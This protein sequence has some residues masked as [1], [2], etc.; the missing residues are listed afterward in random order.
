MQIDKILEDVVD[1]KVSL[2]QT[3]SRVLLLAKKT[4]NAKLEKWAENEANGY[5]NIDDIPDYRKTISKDLIYS[6]INGR[7]QIT[8]GA[9]PWETLPEE[10][11][12]SISEVAIK[13]GI[14]SIEEIANSGQVPA[15]DKSML[16]N[17]IYLNTDGMIQCTSI[18]QRIPLTFFQSICA[19]VKSQVISLLLEDANGEENMLNDKPD[20]ANKVF[21]VHGHDDELR[22]KVQVVLNHGGLEDIVLSEQADDGKTIIEKLEKY[23]SDVAYAVILYTACDIGRDKNLDESCNQYR[24]RQNVVFEHGLLIGKLGRNK[25]SA[26]VK[27]DIEIPGD[28]DGVVYISVDDAG[29]WKGKLA[30]NIS[31]SGIAINI[32]EMIK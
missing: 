22:A 6:G 30:R 4:K 11:Q 9:L 29:A 7:F 31:N 26:L 20:G 21:I 5:S 12:K 17:L 2:E 8:N 32:N 23:S 3:L 27:G 18:M 15:R 25:V 13:E 10:L 14:R 19:A 1:N 24:A 16:A 28:I